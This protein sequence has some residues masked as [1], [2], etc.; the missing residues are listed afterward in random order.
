MV[1]S[2]SGHTFVEFQIL[3]M[4]FKHIW[5]FQKEESTNFLP[6]SISHYS[7]TVLQYYSPECTDLKIRINFN[8]VALSFL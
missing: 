5:K 2:R 1:Y 3:P 6:F 7:P 8:V 4:L